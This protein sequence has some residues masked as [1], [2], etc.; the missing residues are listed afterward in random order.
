M[1]IVANLDPNKS[2]VGWCLFR[3]VPARHGSD[4]GV[5]F[6]SPTL[7]SGLNVPHFNSDFAP[8]C[9]LKPSMNITSRLSMYS[10]NE[11]CNTQIDRNGVPD[12]P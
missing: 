8:D 7:V 4:A 9:L 5:C 12:D 11:A 3:V 1:T 10:S 6:T 2:H